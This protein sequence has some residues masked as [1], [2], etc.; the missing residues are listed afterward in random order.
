MIF[1][2]WHGWTTLENAD[3]Y[4]NLLRRRFSLQF[5]LKIYRVIVEFS[6]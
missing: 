2:I 1:R 4:E 3:I 5:Q 6:F